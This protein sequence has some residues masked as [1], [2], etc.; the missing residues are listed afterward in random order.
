MTRS[1]LLPF[2][3]RTPV[4]TFVLI[5]LV[6]AAGRERADDPHH[7]R[8]PIARM[9]PRR[10]GGRGTEQSEKVAPSHDVPRIEQL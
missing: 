9:R 3:A 1:S 6:V 4:V 5:P 8:R 10:T 7:P 2:L